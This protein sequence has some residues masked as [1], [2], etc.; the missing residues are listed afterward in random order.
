VQAPTQAESYE[1]TI[2][3]LLRDVTV[4]HLV[5]V[6]VDGGSPEIRDPG[7]LLSAVSHPFT[8]VNGT[9][10]YSSGLDQAAAFLES[11]VG[12]HPF[13]DGN[14][15]TG[16]LSTLYFLEACNYWENIVLLSRHEVEHMKEL[17]LRDRL[18]S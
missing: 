8:T 3:Q 7:L 4:A 17:T 14:K 12:N 10:A 18:K 16:M 11:L 6:A 1:A 2:S 9:L 13:M 5:A 15:R